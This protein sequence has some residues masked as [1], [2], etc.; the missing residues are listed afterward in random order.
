MTEGSFYSNPTPSVRIPRCFGVCGRERGT[1]IEQLGKKKPGINSYK[2]IEKARILLLA[3]NLLL[4]FTNK[5]PSPP[6]DLPPLLDLIL[7][8]EGEARFMG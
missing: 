2:I 4:G 8:K 6:P 1:K 3:K 5:N 7:L